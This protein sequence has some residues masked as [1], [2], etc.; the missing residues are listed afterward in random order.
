MKICLLTLFCC[1]TLLSAIGFAA[2]S[3]H[4]IRVQVTVNQ[5]LYQFKS[6]PRLTD[7]LAPVALE[8]DWYWPA[9]ALY[10]HT[11]KPAQLRSQLL[12]L[13]ADLQKDALPELQQTLLSLS[14]QISSW[15]LAERISYS[16]DYDVARIRPSTNP[17]FTEGDYSIR[18]V[19][20]PTRIVVTGAAANPGSLNHQAAADVD[21]YLQ[22]LVLLPGADTEQPVII[23][24][25]G[26][27]LLLTA[28]YWHN[29][30][31]E[32]MPGATLLIPLK[33]GLFSDKFNELNSQ[34]IELARHRVFP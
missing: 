27:V 14:Q 28:G 16:V 20:R 12:D 3:K 32:L 21:S 2:D 18:L 22:Q 15:Q 26:R 29:Q 1:L 24:P 11:A 34:L 13:L 6:L 10:Q 30:H 8:Q 31:L 5:Q 33:P 17:T 9:T 25:D 19:T 23:N 4:E 7:V